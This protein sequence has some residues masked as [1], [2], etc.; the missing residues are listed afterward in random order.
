MPVRPEPDSR[1][2]GSVRSLEHLVVVRESSVHDRLLM[3]GMIHQT[4]AKVQRLPGA[5]EVD[6]AGLDIFDHPD[7]YGA[8][9]ERH[10]KS[11]FG[12][13]QRDTV[14]YLL[15]MGSAALTEADDTNVFV[16][17][18]VEVIAAYRPR[19]VWVASI[20]RLVR[21]A[22]HAGA[23]LSALTRHVEVVHAEQ[24]IHPNTPAGKIQFGMLAMIASAERDFIVQRHTTG[25]VLQWRRGAWIP[26]AWPP[27][28][29][30]DD[31]R[32]LVVDPDQVEAVRRLLGWLADPS[33]SLGEV[34][35]RAGR[36]GVT[37]PGVR[38]FQGDDATI[39]HARTPSAAVRTIIGWLGLYETG[40]YTVYWPNPFPG[41][42]E[43]AGVPVEDTPNHPNGVLRLTHTVPLPEGGWADPT[44]FQT[45]R[46]VR[47]TSSG[48]NRKGGGHHHQQTAPLGGFFTHI[49]DGYE[50]IILG[51][52]PNHYQLHRRPHQPDRTHKGWAVPTEQTEHVATIHRRDLH[53]SIAHGI[54]ATIEQGVPVDL[55][56]TR[57]QP[58]GPL[59][60]VN[61]N[62]ARLH[63]LQGQH[64]EIQRQIQNNL[65]NAELADDPQTARIFVDRIK[66]LQ[67]QAR[68]LQNQ[69][70]QLEHQ[71]QQPQLETTFTTP[72]AFAA[73][74]LA[75]LTTTPTSGPRQLRTA[76]RTIIHNET[77]T[78]HPD[79]RQA[80]WTLNLELPHKNGTIIIGPITGTVPAK[81]PRGS[82]PESAAMRRRRRRELAQTL[83]RLGLPAGNARI[84]AA[85]PHP[86]L[87][88]T[89]TARLTG[90]PHPPDVDPA[91][92]DHIT[93]IYTNPNPRWEPAKWNIGRPSRQHI[94]DL[95]TQH[96][97]TATVTQ[98]TQCGITPDQLRY[99]YRTYP[100]PAGQPILTTQGRGPNRTISLLSCP[101][102]GGW[103]NQSVLTPETQPGVLCP[104]CRKTPHPDSPTY[105]GW[106]LNNG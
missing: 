86:Q 70:T 39:A 72:A 90:R 3:E 40:E 34:A 84:V 95:L 26:N 100:T 73:A 99:L 15:S 63:S 29:R 76:L 98:L 49:R 97:G 17:R 71:H 12:F 65:R 38:R 103:A 83:T 41:V 88:E 93:R 66:T 101:H 60:P 94:L 10:G 33:L 96:G 64:R 67:T 44:T 28:Y 47:H 19:E 89:L 51:S 13:L 25:R 80:T 75:A 69:I 77:I 52:R 5:G 4:M 81:P 106:Y 6:R 7:R 74:A 32:R 20:T 56:P 78:Y 24:D 36:L 105:P 91:W 57:F 61:P 30:L 68:H 31:T 54:I 1:P 45:I 11:V 62:Q 2:S 85:C 55:D 104:N 79:R 92:A 50:Y 46:A 82:N 43:F 9:V 87:A 102:C 21:A 27:G 59:P 18:L 37:T 23:L 42:K 16:S 53:Q 22:E 8:T 35:R 48:P 58:T 14:L